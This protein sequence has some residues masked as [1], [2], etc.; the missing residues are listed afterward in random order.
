MET[1]KVIVA[2]A[3]LAQE[4]RLA[5][6]RLLVEHAPDGMPAGL[7]AERLQIPAPSLSFHLKELWRAGLIAPRQDGRFVWYRA[8]LSAMKHLVAYLTENCC[9]ATATRGPSCGPGKARKPTPVAVP[10]HRRRKSVV[11]P[12]G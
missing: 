6:Y 7:I 12:S 2:L 5:V 4:T 9:R 11:A 10:L 1:S 3:A 8:D